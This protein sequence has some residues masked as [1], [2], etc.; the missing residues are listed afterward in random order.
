MW[1]AIVSFLFLAST[2]G[3]ALALYVGVWNDYTALMACVVGGIVIATI[4]T[5]ATQTAMCPSVFGVC[6]AVAIL[7][8]GVEVNHM[9]VSPAM[10]ALNVA[11][12]VVAIFAA[13]QFRRR[14]EQ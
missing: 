9:L 3:T 2:A 4:E 8:F 10:K 13:L 12:A 7:A 11:A 14:V 1:K 5:V 6:T